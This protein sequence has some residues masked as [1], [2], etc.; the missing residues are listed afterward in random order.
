[1]LLASPHAHAFRSSA[2]VSPEGACYP[3]LPSGE[4][5]PG[6]IRAALMATQ[7][8]AARPGFKRRHIRLGDASTC[9]QHVHP[10]PEGPQT[11]G[12]TVEGRSWGDKKALECHPIDT[13]PSSSVPHLPPRPVA[14]LPR[15]GPA[16]APVS[17]QLALRPTCQ[18]RAEPRFEIPT[19]S[20]CTDSWPWCPHFNLQDSVLFQP[21]SVLLLFW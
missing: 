20:P 14:F 16:R 21:F 13:A 8:R 1:M 11:V 12:I 3:A 6:S 2:P 17:D 10:W 5:G 9:H 4:H 15:S 7:P 18:H 19:P